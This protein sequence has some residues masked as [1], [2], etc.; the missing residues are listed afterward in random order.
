MRSSL[1]VLTPDTPVLARWDDDGWYYR[2]TILTLGRET[3]AYVVADATEGV[4]TIWRENILT[5]DD[6]AERELTSEAAVVA[7]HPNFARSYAPG[8]VLAIHPDMSILIRFFDG[9]QVSRKLDANFIISKMSPR[10]LFLN[11][12]FLAYR[13]HVH[14]F[15]F[16]YL[17]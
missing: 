16:S 17:K 10:R 14:R 11:R 15:W 6:D 8:V 5:D 2:G 12:F 9:M 13:L 1:P 7:L 3:G 4:A